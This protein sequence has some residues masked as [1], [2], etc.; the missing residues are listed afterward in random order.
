MVAHELTITRARPSDATAIEGVLDA[1]AEWHQSRG[2]EQWTPGGF[3][4]EVRGAIDSGDLYV[5]RREGRLVGCF[6]LDSQ[7]PSWMRPW[8]IE[9]GRKPTQAAHLGKLAVI[10]E[11][12][13]RGHGVE[14]LR[15]ASRLAA[16]RGFA[17]VRLH[18]PSENERL[19][20]YYFDAGF[21]HIGVVD[22]G[23][24]ELWVSSVFERS[25]GAGPMQ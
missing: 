2:I 4:D 1:A 13:G 12:A 14:M 24:G 11:V 22:P 23:F 16:E 15:E 20:R 25:T 5:A 7:S 3:R 8:L 19:R 17:F 21:A 18:C 10:R 9:Q 6:L